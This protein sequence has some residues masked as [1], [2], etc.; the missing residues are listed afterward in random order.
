[1]EGLALELLPLASPIMDHLHQRFLQHFVE[2]D[3]VGH[4]EIEADG[5]VDLG[6]LRVAIAFA[7]LAGYT[8]L[9]EEAGEEEAL[10][11]V[12]R[13]V[14]VG[15]GHAARG[16]AR[17]QDDRRRGDDRRLGPVGARR[18]GRSASR[19][20]PPS[21]RCRASASTPA[22]CC[23]ATATTT[24][25]RSTSPRASARAP[26]AAR[27]SSR[28]TV[29]DA[30]GRHLHFE[31]IGEVRLKGFAERD[32]AVPRAARGGGDAS[33]RARREGGLLAGGAARPALRRA[34]LGL[35]ARPRGAARPARC[36]ALHVDYGLRDVAGGDAEHCARAVRAARRAAGRAPR[37]PP[38]AG[39]LQAWA[40]DVRYA[41]AGAPG[42]GRATSRPAT[43]PPTRSRPS[44]TGSRPRRG[45]ARCSACAARDGPRRAAA[46]RRHARGDGRLLRRARAGLA[47]GPDQ[48]LARASP[49]TASAPAWCR[50]CASCT[51]PP[52][53]T[54]CARWRC[55]ATRRRCSTRW[56]TPAV[57]D[58]GGGAGRAAARAARGCACSG[59]PARRAGAAR[60]STE[61]RSRSPRAAARA[62]DL[63][64]GL[65]AVAEY[66]RLR[67]ERGAPRPAGRARRRLAV[68]GPR[69]RSPAAS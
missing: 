65:R 11:V 61:R 68:P 67:F 59:S 17:D 12:E 7:D 52:R 4:L 38:G 21:G 28:A 18:T 24:A 54:C 64:G 25:A 39:N 51:P 27:C 30:A 32:R 10:D 66:G 45:A 29:V 60:G 9:T 69:R 5:E 23:T 58:D 37:R 49:A 22:R 41:E 57:T 8:R 2:Q 53:R 16:R 55:C 47:R 35:P 26:P 43:P 42:R 62:L 48:R 3:V 19:S 6:R 46:A 50:R 15:R 56:S 14:G 63:G 40:R 13:F 33:R 31:R 34:R 20:W 44:S 1:M 36:A